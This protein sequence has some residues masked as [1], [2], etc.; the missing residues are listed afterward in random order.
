MSSHSKLTLSDADSVRIDGAT[1]K[2]KSLMVSFCVRTCPN[3]GGSLV[4]A[5]M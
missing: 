3:L 1:N 5:H 4:R 2:I